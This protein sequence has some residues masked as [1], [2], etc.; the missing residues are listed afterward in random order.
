M[1]CPSE[2]ELQGSSCLLIDGLALVAATERPSGAQMFG[3]FVDSFQAAVLKAGSRY[4]QIHVIFDRYQE[5]SIKSGT[6]KRRTKCTRPIQ[7]VIEDGSVPIPQSWPNFL[8]LPA[9]K[10]DLARFLSEHIIVNSPPPPP[11]DKVVVA[12]GGFVDEREVQSSERAIDLSALKATHE[13]A[14]TRLIL[15]CVNNSL[16]NIVVSARDTKA[17]LLLV[18]HVPHIPCPNLYMMSGTA[19]KRNITTSRRFKCVI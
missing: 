14:D 18:A 17:F 16:D 19:A 4:Q 5:D 8:A 1:N 10:S 3:D 6:R 12:A 15:H 9:N 13:E 7:H 11:P 2:I